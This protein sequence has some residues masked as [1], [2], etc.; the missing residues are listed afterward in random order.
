MEE[1]FFAHRTHEGVFQQDIMVRNA[2][3]FP[4]ELSLT[5]SKT[6]EMEKT[7][8]NTLK[9]PLQT[10]EDGQQL[11]SVSGE[12]FV[13]KRKETEK[14]GVVRFTTLLSKHAASLTI[15]RRGEKTTSLTSLTNFTLVEM[16]IKQ[17]EK[18]KKVKRDAN[19][20]GKSEL[21]KQMGVELI[22]LSKKKLKKEHI[23]AWNQIWMV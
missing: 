4:I 1:E 2:G 16:K 8:K 17:R 15:P 19:I 13:E 12:I 5:A 22:E 6:E 23:D 21:I 20:E 11:H 14:E 9:I 10:T 7:L 3:P 18:K